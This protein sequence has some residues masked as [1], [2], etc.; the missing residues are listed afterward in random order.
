MLAS[1]IR[2]ILKILGKHF[3]GTF[4]RDN[5]PSLKVDEYCVVNLSDS[6]EPGSHWIVLGHTDSESDS[7]TGK[8]EYE[9]FDSLGT[10]PVK[11]SSF[12]QVEA[13]VYFNSCQVQSS[14]SATC[15]E[16]CC[17]FILNRL[18]NKD[19]DFHTVFDLCFDSKDIQRNEERV[20]TFIEQV[21]K[22]E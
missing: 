2:E 15:G 5:I 12:F 11:V 13:T 19:L 1:E 16:F 14:S 7:D 3:R 22:H 18:E 17:Y 10:N 8:P 21:P 6:N 20:K 4:P 9:Y